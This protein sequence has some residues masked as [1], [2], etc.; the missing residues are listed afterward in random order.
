[1]VMAVQQPL[2]ECTAIFAMC[3]VEHRTPLCA[4]TSHKTCTDRKWSRYQDSAC[5]PDQ[6]S[7][8]WQ[9]TKQF[10]LSQQTDFNV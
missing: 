5:I 4:V 8:S 10:D 3:V 9:H 1:M 6:R 2:A 7:V